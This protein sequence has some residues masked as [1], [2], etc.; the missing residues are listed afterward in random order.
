MGIQEITEFIFALRKS[1]K[2]VTTNYY[3]TLQ[4]SNE[5]FET[6]TAQ[7]SI[8]F[9]ARENRLLRCFFASTDERELNDLL[10]KVPEGA[11]FDFVSREKIEKFSWE[12]SGFEHYRTLARHVNPDIF[13]QGKKSKREKFLEQFYQADFG[14]FAT[15]E[16]AEEIYD[17]LY[18]VFDYRVSRLPSKEELLEQIDKNW[19]LLYREEGNIIAFLMYQIEG[20]KYYGYQIYNKGTADISYNLERTAIQYA[21][22][23]YQVKSSYAWVEINNFAANKRVGADF[24][25][26]YDYIFLKRY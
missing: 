23:T 13:A 16:D 11:V 9:C 3:L 15:A 22:S 19:V 18:K 2:K 17:L 10:R 8:V 4:N 24:D 6:L 21:V 14:E 12:E 20:K 1:K 25:G 26:T 7:N 5:D